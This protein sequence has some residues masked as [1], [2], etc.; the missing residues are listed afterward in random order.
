[1]AL[2]HPAI[3]SLLFP[4]AHPHAGGQDHY[5]ACLAST[6]AFEVELAAS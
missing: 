1:M 2:N 5:A 3:G 6:D 4:E